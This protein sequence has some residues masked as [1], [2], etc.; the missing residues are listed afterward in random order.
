VAGGMWVLYL[1]TGQESSLLPST[2]M[3]LT[4]L[5]VEQN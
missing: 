3:L 5:I 2:F 1:P 4:L